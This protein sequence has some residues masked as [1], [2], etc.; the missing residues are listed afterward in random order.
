[1]PNGNWV[2]GEMAEAPRA[3]GFEWGFTA[4]PALEEGGERASY[5]FFEQTWMPKGAVN[6]DLGKQFIAY[7][8]SDEAAD[9]FATVGGAVQPIKG[10]SDKLDGDAKLYYSV[11]DTGA[12][13]VMDA[14]ATTDPVEGI[15]VRTTFF[16]PVDSLVTG[17][18]T[19]EEWVEQI[20][21]D[22]D[23]LRAALKE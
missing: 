12:V 9:I 1:M 11:Y 7:L 5:T 22:S 23:E 21:K 15:T 14:F 18:K 3:E 17:D 6:Q 16:D 8:Y 19:E 13:A 10:M 20:K 4:L 2:I